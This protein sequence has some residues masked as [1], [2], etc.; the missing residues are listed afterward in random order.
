MKKH[1][2]LAFVE[3]K[4]GVLARISGLF[5]RRGFN[6]ESLAV[7]HAE[8]EGFSRMTIVV[9]GEEKEVDQVRKQLSKL[10]EVLEVRNIT[11]EAHVGR[12]LALLKVKASPKTRSQ[13]IEIVDIFR[14]NIVDIGPNS[15]MV[16][17]SG[18]EDKINALEALLRPYG[19]LALSR[20]GLIALPRE[21]LEKK[22]GK[23]P[24]RQ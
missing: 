6:I 4:P 22:E 7:G 13:I 18:D 24:S 3:D 20:T 10:I 8:K 2:L 1:T 9:A 5:A 15:V 17:I 14:A 12:E 23:A 16:E 11:E 19:L 21:A